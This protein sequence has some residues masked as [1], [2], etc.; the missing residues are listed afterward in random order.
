MKIKG[1]A[2]APLSTET[3]TIDVTTGRTDA[4]VLQVHR[5]SAQPREEEHTLAAPPKFRHVMLDPVNGLWY[6]G[7]FGPFI[8]KE[9]PS[10][11][12][13]DNNTYNRSACFRPKDGRLYVGA[14]NCGRVQIFNKPANGTRRGQ[15]NPESYTF[16]DSWTHGVT[17]LALGT[18][19]D[20]VGRF[21]ALSAH[22]NEAG[23]RLLHAGSMQPPGTAHVL[24]DPTF[25]VDGNS[26]FVSIDPSNSYAFVAGTSALQRLTLSSNS[27]LVDF[28]DPGES[29]APPV[30][31]ERAG[32]VYC[33]TV[34]RVSG[35]IQAVRYAVNDPGSRTPRDLVTT[36]AT[37]AGVAVHPTTQNLWVVHADSANCFRVFEVETTGMAIVNKVMAMTSGGFSQ[38]WRTSAGY[39]MLWPK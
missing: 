24:D 14:S 17:D 29:C 1:V 12:T 20:E 18:G 7:M 33:F 19:R 21:Y 28:R 10:G 6:Y 34:E 37:C 30:F 36:S 9:A 5:G 16:S 32:T 26:C 3:V 39:V 11:N 4:E 31:S 22:T 38:F 35:K 8:L 2:H 27:S 23:K 13:L 15:K 25:D